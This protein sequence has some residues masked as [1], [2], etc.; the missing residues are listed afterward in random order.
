ME[1]LINTKLYKGLN[2]AQKM[3]GT[4]EL[5]SEFKYSPAMTNGGQKIA[6]VR[7][8]KIRRAI[9]LLL[10]ML[11]FSV[12]AHAKYGGGTGEPDDPY[13]IATAEQ[14]I[15]IGSEESDPQLLYK[16]FILLNNIDLDP[17]L[18]GGQVFDRAVIPKF[19]GTFDGNGFIISN[20]T[21]VGDSNLG[22]FG[23]IKEGAQINHLNIADASVV[24]T[25][26]RIGILSGSNGDNSRIGGRIIGCFVSGKV[27]G[28]RYVGGL[29]GWNKGSV[30]NCFSAGISDGS[31]YVGGLIG[32]NEGS[33]Y[34]LSYGTVLN[35]YS[36]TIVSG[37]KHAGGLVGC[38]AFGSILNC[39]NSSPVSGGTNIGGLIG[40][41]RGTILNC[42]SNGMVSGNVFVGGLVGRNNGYY[43]I[44][45]SFWDMETSGQVESAGG[46]GLTTDKM[47]DIT[48]Y[49]DAG[50]DF[51]GE[52]E[53]GL[54]EIWTISEDS[55][56]P[57][58]SI[59]HGFEP[60]KLS[61]DGTLDFPYLISSASE[62]GAVLHYK[63]D[64]FYQMT[65]DIDLSGITWSISLIPELSGS[66][67]GQGLTIRNLSIVGDR[68]LG[69]IGTLMPGAEVRNLGVTNAKIDGT[70]NFI[71]IISGY[72]NWGT[73]LN[74][75]STGTAMGDE[76]VGG[77]IGENF[78]GKV[79]N[80]YSASTLRG[81]ILVGGLVGYNTSGKVTNSYSICSVSGERIVGGLVGYNAE[82]NILNCYNAGPASGEKTIGGL[83]GWNRGQ[84][85][86]CYSNGMVSGNINV[87]GLVGS[88]SEADNSFWDIETSGQLES[89][90]GT[91]LVTAAMQDI[92]TYLNAG[93][94]F[95]DET[96]NSI[97]DIW[98]MPEQD[99]P[100]LTW[101]L[102]DFSQR[103][104]IN[105]VD[106]RI[107][108]II[109]VEGRTQLGDIF[110]T[111]MGCI[112]NPC[113]NRCWSS[114]ILNST[115]GQLHL[116]G[117][118]INCTG[119]EC[120]VTCS[121]VQAGRLYVIEGILRDPMT[122]EV[123]DYDE[124]PNIGADF[125]LVDDF[126]GYNDIDPEHPESNRI[127]MTW[128]D[129]FDS[130]T[131]GS[132]VDSSSV[133]ERLLWIVI[134]HSGIRSMCLYYDNSN[135]AYISEATANV[136]NLI[137]GRDWTI[138]GVGV[139]S[140]WFKGDSSNAVE[141]MYVALANDNGT[142]AVIYHYNPEVA[143]IDTWMEYRIDLQL[144][145]NQGVDLTNVNTVSIGFGD[146]NNPQPG[147][148]GEMW[149][150]DIRLYRPVPIEPELPPVWP[151]P[152]PIEPELPPF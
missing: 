152:V 130:I 104:N 51:W 20:L 53:N 97:E 58:L 7:N 102:L 84:V 35:S 129:G 15:S 142:T 110:C 55:D 81:E 100:H 71:G 8:R 95:I 32:N 23:K 109:R 43:N 105:Y 92:T 139:L 111:L 131:N 30:L 140:L 135:P 11:Y 127:W 49:K 112:N 18:P 56:Y 86:N 3:P 128:I 17:N 136:D 124:I 60:P 141:P 82:G 65:T 80:S 59:F 134:S 90:G 40:F 113:C 144:F 147:G 38:N 29:V 16:H 2:S 121:P 150:D 76:N 137:I 143:M 10:V 44:T 94:D 117:E 79:I 125:I 72:N 87:G 126:E 1:L 13:Q 78:F 70:G 118:D 115:E 122:L 148:R 4:L 149:F 25:G 119:T 62:L 36:T 74:C 73:V 46:I 9:Y 63:P 132:I 98:F 67:D 39:Y 91:G 24:G 33:Y 88:E 61:G 21:I 123:I 47:K 5:F 133:K 83:V 12:P 48:T 85:L 66:F 138:E 145:A 37:G 99:Y 108:R 27:R 101:E 26:D 151:W 103:I 41:N 106:K 114:L 120:G 54:H 50:W 107:G 89:V 146:K 14:L 75:Y 42:Y 57:V 22:L 45:S 52:R 68:G 6:T 28:D 34:N 19:S 77:L 31:E 96:E 116:I 69:L 64:A 93:W